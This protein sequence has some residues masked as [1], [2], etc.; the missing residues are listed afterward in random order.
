MRKTVII[1]MLCVSLWGCNFASES[2]QP[3]TK[4]VRENPVE[5]Y[6][7]TPTHYY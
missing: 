2:Y 7:D 5:Y 4:G 3:G 1:L 6:R